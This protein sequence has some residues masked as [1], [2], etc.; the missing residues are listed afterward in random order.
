MGDQANTTAHAEP[1]LQESLLGTPGLRSTAA[2]AAVVWQPA[3]ACAVLPSCLMQAVGRPT[4]RAAAAS[5]K[6]AA[7]TTQRAQAAVSAAVR[8]LQPEAP[9]AELPLEYPT[10]PFRGQPLP[11]AAGAVTS[12]HKDLAAAEAEAVTLRRGLGA[13]AGET[14]RLKQELSELQAE[15]R[16]L[17]ESTR[18]EA[19]RLQRAVAAAEAEA[20]E[21]R[22]ALIAT[23][24]SA[25]AAQAALAASKHEAAKA[26]Q[27]LAK[28]AQ[29]A[30]AAAAAAASREQAAAAAGKVMHSKLAEAGKRAEQLAAELRD[31]VQLR[32][33]A[34]TASKETGQ[35]AW[36]L[37]LYAGSR[38]WRNASGQG[39]VHVWP[40]ACPCFC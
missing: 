33:Q 12:L 5:R 2:A 16:Q 40:M 25:A 3:M 7:L 28:Q 36:A 18:D 24:S 34:V 13:A 27:Q 20:D 31:E 9:P 21:L 8:A 1:P 32:Q 19:V 22:R 37:Q 26:R 4:V 38:E 17:G 6:W 15:L 23:N 30:E 14:S 10:K 29:M 11:A 35:G 39:L